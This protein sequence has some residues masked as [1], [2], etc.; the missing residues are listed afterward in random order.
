MSLTL[1]DE[2]VISTRQDDPITLT[3]L[4]DLP[5]IET[6]NEVDNNSSD[7]IV[8]IPKLDVDNVGESSDSGDDDSSMTF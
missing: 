6:E 4:D 8:A 1:E 7:G 5:P 2:I 3:L